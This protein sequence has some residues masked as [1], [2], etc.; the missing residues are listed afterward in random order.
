MFESGS[1]ADV[2][3]LDFAKAFDKVDH[4]ILMKKLRLM[5]VGEPLLAWIRCFLL[6]D[7]CR[8]RNL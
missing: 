4:G 5:G 2:V 7:L 6:G 1:V 3:Y 8:P